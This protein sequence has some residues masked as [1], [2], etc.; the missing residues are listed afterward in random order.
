MKLRLE[1]ISST[2]S[3]LVCGVHIKGPADSWVRFALLEIPWSAVPPE[4]I[5]EFW[6]WY[7][8][9]ERDYAEDTPLAFE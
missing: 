2:R 6:R 4:T 1:Q 3:G 8:R 5:A 7:D 9:D